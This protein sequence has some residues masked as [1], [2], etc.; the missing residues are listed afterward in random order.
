LVGDAR[1]DARVKG[2]D[3][4]PAQMFS[5]ASLFQKS[6]PSHAE[7][8]PSFMR[9]RETITGGTMRRR[10]LVFEPIK[11]VTVAL[12][13]AV[14]AKRLLV[15]LVPASTLEEAM[16][17]LRERPDALLIGTSSFPNRDGLTLLRAARNDGVYGPAVVFT[18]ERDFDTDNDILDLGAVSMTKPESDTLFEWLV[19]GKPSQERVRRLFG[20]LENKRADRISE[21]VTLAC[22]DMRR[23]LNGYERQLLEAGR[24][25][26]GSKNAAADYFGLHRRYVQG[27]LNEDGKRAEEAAPSG[28]RLIQ[29]ATLKRARRA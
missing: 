23:H 27:K 7:H 8:R 19:D 2:D 10:V 13:R 6:H 11:S 28:T 20:C 25:R 17:R 24:A 9:W 22:G 3:S 5:G 12:A 26:Y 21:G 14:R 29:P 16:G 18:T 1:N 15:T 4:S